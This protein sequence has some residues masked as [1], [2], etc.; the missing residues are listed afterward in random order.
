MK[1]LEKSTDKQISYDSYE[2]PTRTTTETWNQRSGSFE[3]FDVLIKF[4]NE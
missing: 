1:S 4:V 2:I 3:F